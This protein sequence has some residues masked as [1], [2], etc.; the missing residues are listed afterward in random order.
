MSS[1]NRVE[2]SVNSLQDF[3]AFVFPDFRV[4]FAHA[5]AVTATRHPRAAGAFLGAWAEIVVNSEALAHLKSVL[6]V[7]AITL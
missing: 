7:L 6:S 1:I 4:L 2:Q 3:G 5:L